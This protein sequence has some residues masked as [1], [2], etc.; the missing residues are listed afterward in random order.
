MKKPKRIFQLLLLLSLVVVFIGGYTFIQFYFRPG[1]IEGRITFKFLLSLKKVH[2]PA[3]LVNSSNELEK[4]L[5]WLEST[6]KNKKISI[7]P[8]RHT[9]LPVIEIE[10]PSKPPHHRITNLRKNQTLVAINNSNTIHNIRLTSRKNQKFNIVVPPKGSNQYDIQFEECELHMI[11]SCDLHPFE[12]EY[13]SVFDH[14]LFAVTDQHG[15]FKI[16][17]VPAG[18]YLLKAWHPKLGEVEQKVKIWG[19]RTTDVQIEFPKNQ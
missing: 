2:Q 5:V 18:T 7:A 1:N 12:Q 8:P 19:T 10:Y 4:A 6:N 13:V 17:D 15:K 11:L 9:K 3:V 14:H 16:K